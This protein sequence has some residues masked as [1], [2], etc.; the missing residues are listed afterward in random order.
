MPNYNYR[1]AVCGYSME[2]FLPMNH[3]SPNCS[4]MDCERPDCPKDKCLIREYS[5]PNIIFRGSGWTETTSQTKEKNK[6]LHKLYK[7]SAMND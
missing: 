7:D 2:F 5:T 1:C 3:K 4:E 6:K